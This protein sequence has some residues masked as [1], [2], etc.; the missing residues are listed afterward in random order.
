VSASERVVAGVSLTTR[1]GT[2]RM[3]HGHRVGGPTGPPSPSMRNEEGEVDFSHRRARYLHSQL[4]REER[5]R[6][7]GGHRQGRGMQP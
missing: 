2:A 3:L 1:E 4:V 7:D 6:G 5:Y